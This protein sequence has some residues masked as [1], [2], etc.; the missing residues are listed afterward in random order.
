MAERPCVRIS[1]AHGSLSDQPES[2]CGAT[3]DLTRVSFGCGPPLPTVSDSDQRWHQV[4]STI[5]INRWPA[6]PVEFGV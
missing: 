6:A 3:D 4:V 2:E 1:R 5:N